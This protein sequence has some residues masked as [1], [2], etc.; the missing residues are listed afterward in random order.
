[1]P[2]TISWRKTLAAKLGATMLALLVAALALIVGNL[3]MLS[4]LQGDSTMI[5]VFGKGRALSYQ[6]LYLVNRHFDESGEGRTRVRDELNSVMS[7]MDQR[8][9]SLLD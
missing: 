3:Y 7:S 4:S 9:V 2:R 6:I 8:Y 5:N 1:M